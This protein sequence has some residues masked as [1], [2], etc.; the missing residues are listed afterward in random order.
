MKKNFPVPYRSFIKKLTNEYFTLNYINKG[1]FYSLFLSNFIFVS[2]FENLILEFISPFLAIYGLF[3]LIGAEKQIYFWCGFFIG[4]IWFYWISFSLIYFDLS[5]LIPL[6][7]LGIAFFYGILFRICA[8]S[9]NKLLRAFLLIFINFIHPFSFNWLNLNLIFIYGIFEPNLRALI[10]ILMGILA[11]YHLEYYKKSFFAI[12]LIFGLQFSQTKPNLLPFKTELVNT[13]ISQ[14]DIWEIEKIKT[15]IDENMRKI[16][17][18]IKENYKFIIFPETAFAFRLNLQ[19]NILDQLKEKSHKITILVGAEG[20]DDDKIYNSA[21]LFDNGKMQR[22][23][24]FI[25]VPF[26]E[27]IPLPNFAKNLINDMIFGGGSD[28]SKASNFSEYEV[29]GVKIVNAIC[30]EATRPEIYKNAP[31]IVV[32]IS[33]NGWFIP[34]TQ[35]ILQRLLI[36]YYATLSGATIY[37]AVNGSKSEI[38]TPKEL[39]IKKF[40]K[41]SYNSTKK[42]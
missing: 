19:N 3:R 39:W 4:L 20:Q 34:S 15:Q 13:Q 26:G 18:A 9:D 23:D 31:K 5:Y 29:G 6:E 24:K 21:Y 12:F 10:A 37:H 33:N 17:I 16:D 38:I 11:Y 32:A 41:F 35:P 36:R 30:Y 2:F 14:N 42:F 1:F 40:F 7:I 27:E 22:F 28:F 25:L 8:I